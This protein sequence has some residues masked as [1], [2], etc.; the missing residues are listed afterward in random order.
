[1]VIFF[2]FTFYPSINVFQFQEGAS[3]TNDIEIDLDDVLDMD[4]DDERRK[5]LTP[6]FV[7]AKKSQDVV[8]VSIFA[9]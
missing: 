4:G 5:F 6:I 1:M 3:S 2:I 9:I 7:D 8:N